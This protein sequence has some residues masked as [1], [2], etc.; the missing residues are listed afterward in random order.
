MRKRARKRRRAY[1]RRLNM[2]SGGQW[3]G[4]CDRRR[5]SGRLKLRNEGAGRAMVPVPVIVTRLAGTVLMKREMSEACRQ[6]AGMTVP[7]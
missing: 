5:K 6:L 2:K 3:R 7:Q 4:E 1:G